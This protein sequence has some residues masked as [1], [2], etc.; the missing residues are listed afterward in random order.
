MGTAADDAQRCSNAATEP[1]RGKDGFLYKNLFCAQCNRVAEFIKLYYNLYCNSKQTTAS[2][3]IHGG[4]PVDYLEICQLKWLIPAGTLTDTCYKSTCADE[5]VRSGLNKYCKMYKAPLLYYKDYHCFQCNPAN[6]SLEMSSEDCKKQVWFPKTRWSYFIQVRHT[7]DG[8]EA[9]V[10]ETDNEN[11]GN[12]SIV[13][14]G[15]QRNHATQFIP[16]SCST[17]L[18]PPG[19]R[20][21][22]HHVRTNFK[23][24]LCLLL[25]RFDQ[26]FHRQGKHLKLIF[27]SHL[28]A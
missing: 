4:L 26:R 28:T 18:C 25:H 5:Y 22:V 19:Y 20:Q 13:R 2:L 21:N 14:E 17:R 11:L 27:Y 23:G 9:V 16:T 24:G 1:V 3:G 12:V 10:K 15:C 7:E 8:P 6:E